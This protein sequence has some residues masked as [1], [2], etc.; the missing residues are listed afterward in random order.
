M[1]K[2]YSTEVFT[3][4]PKNCTFNG[5]R[6]LNLGCG[7]ATFPAGNVVNLDAY[8]ESDCLWNLHITPLPFES[9]S[10]DFIIANHVLEHLPHDVWWRLFEDCARILK[11]GGKMEIWVPADGSDSIFGFRDHCCQINVNSFFGVFGTYRAA[12]NAWAAENAASP[13][14]RMKP[15]HKNVHF[16]PHWWLKWG[17]SKWQDWCSAHLR[18]VALEQ[19]FLF[20]KVTDEE[21]AAEMKKCPERFR[22]P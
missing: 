6:V 22:T 21:M 15:V 1:S 2:H 18:N 12:H 20:R 8:G 13:A 19:G 16:F 17:G 11:V 4:Y 7:F 3:K 5:D 14:N 10:F 9:E